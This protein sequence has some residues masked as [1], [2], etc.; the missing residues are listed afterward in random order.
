MPHRPLAP[1]RHAAAAVLAAL[2]AVAVTTLT[3]LGPTAALPSPPPPPAPTVAAATAAP[4]PPPGRETA[5]WP[6]LASPVRYR[7]PVSAA[8]AFAVELVGFHDPVTGPFR[9]GVDGAGAI[10][11]QPTPDG[12]TTTVLLRRLDDDN[13][14]VLGA[15]T[16]DILL[17][18]PRAG[19]TLGVEATLAG[20]AWALGGSLAARILDD[21]AGDALASGTID[22][23]PG[24]FHPFSQRFPL[25]GPQTDHGVVLVTTTDPHSG[26]IRSAT[27]VRVALIR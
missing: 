18:R 20:G 15:A 9:P 1:A 19:S 4:A 26:Q 14:W 16:Q 6:R 11:V 13:W 10:D 8:R 21:S 22:V 3:L 7:D 12:P 5:V 25:R 2:A 17:D 27:V 24:G 23:D